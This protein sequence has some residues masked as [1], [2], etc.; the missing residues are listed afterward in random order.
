MSNGYELRVAE[1]ESARNEAMDRWFSARPAIQRTAEAERIWEG[2]FRMAYE[3]REYWTC[4]DCNSEVPVAH[5]EK[6]QCGD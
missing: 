3:A 6:H 1:Y 4:P 2:G 5:I